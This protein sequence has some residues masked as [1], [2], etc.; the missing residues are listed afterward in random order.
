MI[1]RTINLLTAFCVAILALPVGAAGQD[2]NIN[3]P[4]TELERRLGEDDFEVVSCTPSRGLPGERTC[5][6]AL[7]Y[8][9]GAM[10]RSKWAPAPKGGG[11]FNNRPR[12]EL[13]AYAVQKL[14]LD[15]NEYVVPPTAGRCVAMTDYPPSQD[16][17]AMPIQATFEDWNMVLVV[18]QFWPW[19]VDGSVEAK[20]ILDKKRIKEDPLY[21][22][23]ATN[24]NLFTYLIKHR[25]SNVGN[26]LV[27]TDPNNPRVFSVDNGIAFSGGEE[28]NRGNW[29]EK[30][31]V[32]RF[33]RKSIDRLRALTLEDLH[34]QLGVVA[35]YEVQGGAMVPVTP[36]AN[37]DPGDGIR[38]EGSV[39]QLG[40]K[41]NEIE[42]LY[43]RIQDLLEDVDKGKYELF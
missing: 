35:Q 20:K 13:A 3:L 30:I 16:P 10:L 32:D 12:L 19:N 11:E 39:L 31:R 27:S 17:S 14:F 22:R 38:R 34:A 28:S 9:D 4:V 24:F 25:D 1:R 42:R 41:E 40:L 33:S 8:E 2:S 18:L 21:A 23:H 15:E 43:G 5:A 26:F 6:A 7:K 37:L 29:L 36:T